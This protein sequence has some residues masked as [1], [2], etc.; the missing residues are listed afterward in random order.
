MALRPRVQYT[1]YRGHVKTTPP[2]VEP[3]QASEVWNQLRLDED[4]DTPL[5]ELYI[6]AAREQCEEVTGRALIT[7]QWRLTL[8]NWPNQGEPWWDGVKQ[9]PISELR[10]S[11]RASWV[12]LPRYRLQGVDEIRVFD[13]DGN[14][15]TVPLGQFIED[16]EQEPG[17]LV[18]RST[19]TWPVA[20]Q[21]A[22]AVEIDYTAGYGDEPEDVPAALRVALL[23]MVSTMYEHRGDDCS[24][25]DAMRQSGAKAVFDRFKV[26]RV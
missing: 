12:I 10:A 7:Q 14:A 18:L 1:H 19:A 24:A 21:R 3:I 8:D 16:K 9:L 4:T 2:A 5:I 20:L 22:N 26:Q 15:E 13:F 11:G 17:R 23:Q 6:T 25:V